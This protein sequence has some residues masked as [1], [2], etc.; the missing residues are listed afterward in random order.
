MMNET[1]R[2]VPIENFMAQKP[3]DDDYLFLMNL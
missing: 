3:V 1:Y 2:T